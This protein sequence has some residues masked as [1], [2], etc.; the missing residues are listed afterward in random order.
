MRVK[1][2]NVLPGTSG[3]DPHKLSFPPYTTTSF[4]LGSYLIR[5]CANFQYVH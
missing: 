4:R 3:H 2:Y 5:D 1:C